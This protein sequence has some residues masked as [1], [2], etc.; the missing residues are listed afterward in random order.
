MLIIA[1]T[2]ITAVRPIARQRLK[3]FPAVTA[4]L[5]KEGLRRHRRSMWLPVSELEWDLVDES[6]G[7][8]LSLSFS[9]PPGAFAT[10]VLDMLLRFRLGN[11]V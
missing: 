8:V 5:E 1:G 4:L 3:T 2:T 11:S 6:A 7:S 10:T 9:L